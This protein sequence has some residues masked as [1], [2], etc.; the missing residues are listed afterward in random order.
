MRSANALERKRSGLLKKQRAGRAGAQQRRKI[1]V[2]G[3]GQVTQGFLD[4]GKRFLS[5]FRVQWEIIKGP[6]QGK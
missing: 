4:L 2:L 5:S 1:V 6:L 3:K